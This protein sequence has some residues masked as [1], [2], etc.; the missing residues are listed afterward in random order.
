[1]MNMNFEANLFADSL[2]SRSPSLLRNRLDGLLQDE[3]KYARGRASSCAAST[4][5]RVNLD[6][7]APLSNSSSRSGSLADLRKERLARA[8]SMGPTD[9]CSP[10]AS[11]WPAAT[12]AAAAA[13]PQAASQSPVDSCHRRARLPADSARPRASSMPLPPSMRMFPISETESGY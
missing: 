2:T 1:M 9:S 10:L 3:P 6:A 5:A 7:P 8:A 4:A 11:L 13:A 12:M